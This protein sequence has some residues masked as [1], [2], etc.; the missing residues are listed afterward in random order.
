MRTTNKQ[1]AENNA[2][3]FRSLRPYWT[4]IWNCFHRPCRCI[5]N[6]KVHI[7]RDTAL[8]R[9]CGLFFSLQSGA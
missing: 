5:E 3:A 1:D 8:K 9:L 7:S 6:D 4:A 2:L